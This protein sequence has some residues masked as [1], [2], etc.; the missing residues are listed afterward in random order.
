MNLTVYKQILI[1]AKYFRVLTQTLDDEKY[2]F[3]YE[4]N[5]LL[6]SNIAVDT[7]FIQKFQLFGACEMYRSFN[8][9]LM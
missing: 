7:K 4:L 6:A 5:N 8:L 1:G 3:V 9:C 2:I